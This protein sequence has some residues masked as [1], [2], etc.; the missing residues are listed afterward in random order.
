MLVE[1]PAIRTPAEIRAGWGMTL[2]L[3]FAMGTARTGLRQVC[4]KN[5]SERARTKSRIAAKVPSDL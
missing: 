3:A 5:A 1:P 4:Q 2:Q